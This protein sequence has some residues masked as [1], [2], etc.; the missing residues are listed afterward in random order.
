MIAPSFSAPDHCA[1][2]TVSSWCHFHFF[3]SERAATPG[4]I[5]KGSICLCVDFLMKDSWITVMK[6]FTIWPEE[7]MSITVFANLKE[8]H[9]TRVNSVFN[10]KMGGGEQKNP[11]TQKIT[12]KRPLLAVNPSSFVFVRDAVWSGKLLLCCVCTHTFISLLQLWCGSL[13]QP[14]SPK[15]AVLYYTSVT[16]PLFS[17]WLRYTSCD[18]SWELLIHIWVGQHSSLPPLLK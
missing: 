5:L 7:Q 17:E 11:N 2:T 18:Y 6:T 16:V 14:L 10:R 8:K 4:M 15:S 13:K 3:S 9:N 1:R 12:F